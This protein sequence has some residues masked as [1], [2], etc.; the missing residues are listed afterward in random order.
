MAGMLAGASDVQVKALG[1]FGR[2]LGMSFQ[3]VDDVLDISANE[4]ELGKPA[5]SDLRQGLT[6]LPVILFLERG[7][8]TG[9]VSAVLGGQRSSEQVMAAVQAIRASGALDVAMV[10]ARD[11]AARAR[12]ILADLPDRPARH[13]LLSLVDYVTERRT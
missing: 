5:G 7:Q 4:A 12:T 8:N 9:V 13:A 6:T 3:V 10:E 2:E 11:Y 1:S